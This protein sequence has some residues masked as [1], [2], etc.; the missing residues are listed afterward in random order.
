[1]REQVLVFLGV[2]TPSVECVR[3][4]EEEQ[5]AVGEGEGAF[6]KAGAQVR[7]SLSVHAPIV[8]KPPHAILARSYRDFFSSLAFFCWRRMRSMRQLM[9]WVLAGFL[10]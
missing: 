2:V 10:R 9:S 5:S 6:E 3:V 8:D 7:R 4:G 1:V